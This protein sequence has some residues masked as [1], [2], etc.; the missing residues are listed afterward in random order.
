MI[1]LVPG[2]RV[3]DILTGTRILRH[4][5][6]AASIWRIFYNV[7]NNRGSILPP[8]YSPR[9]SD[10][11]VV[12]ANIG[13]AFSVWNR[14]DGTVLVFANPSIPS[15]NPHI[16]QRMSP[17]IFSSWFVRTEGR[18]P[19]V[20]DWDDK[21]RYVWLSIQMECGGGKGEAALPSF[22]GP[23]LTSV[24]QLVWNPAD[25]LTPPKVPGGPWTPENLK[26]WI[27][28]VRPGAAV[29]EN[30]TLRNY[31]GGAGPSIQEINFFE[32]DTL[33][34][35]ERILEKLGGRAPRPED[36]K[37]LEPQVFQM[38]TQKTNS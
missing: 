29:G 15:D 31:K 10:Q 14:K 3:G 34:M 22:S 18:L 33:R 11:Y 24:E 9:K 30:S 4:W 6:R 38:L 1:P 20:M 16:Y 12:L 8:L 32:A 5:L 13:E 19:D 25:A 23:R 28:K 35:K 27:K 26:N 37:G 17:A 36:F 2:V 21:A 7:S